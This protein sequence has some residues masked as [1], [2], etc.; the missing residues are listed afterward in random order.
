MRGVV[1]GGRVGW[2]PGNTGRGM[3]AGRHGI[4][5]QHLNIARATSS[6]TLLQALRLL[7]GQEAAR[8][9]V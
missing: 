8:G 7:L 3:L 6:V 2:C 5:N 4:A 9:R 1:E